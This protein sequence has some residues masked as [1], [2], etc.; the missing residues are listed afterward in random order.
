[1]SARR[2]PEM[3]PADWK[4]GGILA[5]GKF[6]P[7][8]LELHLERSGEVA[9][10]DER[11]VGN[12]DAD[13]FQALDGGHRLVFE[14]ERDDPSEVVEIRGQVEGE[15]VT[16]NSPGQLDAD[17]RHLGIANPYAGQAGHRRG[18]DAKARDVVDERLLE[19]PE[20]CQKVAAVAI[21]IED[22]VTDQLARPVVRDVT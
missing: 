18:A 21:K 8:R 20:I 6:G 19:P 11:G 7:G 5:N 2:P 10:I 16:R 13:A 22:R 9:A 1:M 14:A 12:R 3:G 15:A 4:N 17:R